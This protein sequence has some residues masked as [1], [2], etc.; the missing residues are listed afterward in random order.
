MVRTARVVAP[1][2]LVIGLMGGCST[3][4]AS[5]EDR[6]ELIRRATAALGEWNSDVP[7]LEAFARH[8]YGYAMFPSIAKGGLGIGAAYGRGV[9]WEQGEHIGYADLSHASVGLQAG[10]QAYQ[11]LVVFDDK[12]ALARFKDGPLDF[13]ADVSGVLLEGGYVATFRFVEGVTVFS[14]PI[15]GAMGEAS[16]GGQWFTFALR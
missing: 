7:G 14:R 9:V 6:D 11:V 4:P 10:G 8:G 1:L 2:V 16:L 15:G 13:S 12:A 3:A 5:Q